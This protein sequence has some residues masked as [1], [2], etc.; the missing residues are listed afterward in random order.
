MGVISLLR[1][2]K[3]QRSFKQTISE[4]IGY[5]PKKIYLFERVFTHRSLEK[6]DDNGK[7]INY[8]RLEFLGD[9]VLGTIIGNY[10]FTKMPNADEGTLT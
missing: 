3:P 5:K 10:L 8:E 1:K 7:K 4:I 9:A 6:V 2:S